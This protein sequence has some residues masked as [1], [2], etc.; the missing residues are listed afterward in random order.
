ML[1]ERVD[2]LEQYGRRNTLEI[3]GIPAARE[4]NTRDL[5]LAAC[6]AVGV[7]LRPEAIDCCHRLAKGAN[8]RS[9]GIIPKFVRRDVAHMVLDKKKQMRNLSSRAVGVQGEEHSVFINL[10]LTVMRRK[11]LSQVKKLQKDHGFKYVWVDKAGNIK[12]RPVYKGRVTVIN[13]DTELNAFI[14][15]LA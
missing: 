3:H 10:S 11:I 6:K 4:E 8:Q 15:A 9:P 5:V 2:A 14:A 13:N 1:N 12:V 7:E